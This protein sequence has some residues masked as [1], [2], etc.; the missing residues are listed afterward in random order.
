[1]ELVRGLKTPLFVPSNFTFI[2]LNSLLDI[3]FF[4]QF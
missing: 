1:M 3:S 4:S 2:A